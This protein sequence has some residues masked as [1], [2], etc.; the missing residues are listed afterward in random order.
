MTIWGSLIA[1]SSHLDQVLA[2]LSLANYTRWHV[3]A[4]TKYTWLSPTVNNIWLTP[5][6]Y[7]GL[8][9]TVYNTWLAPT[10]YLT[11]SDSHRRQACIYLTL[12][13][14]FLNTEITECFVGASS[15][16]C[17]WLSPT[18]FV[19]D[20]PVSC[21]SFLPQKGLSISSVLVLVTIS[22]SPQHIL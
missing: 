20:T 3:L 8:S 18:L 4:P 16:H 5:T 14:T 7:T 1:N 12:P 9:P 15:C 10:L 19:I 11:I 6:K 2:H 22:Y 13:N 17:I 21:N